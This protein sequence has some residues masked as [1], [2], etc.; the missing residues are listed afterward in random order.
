MK[1][2]ITIVGLA[3]AGLSVPALAQGGPPADPYGDATVTRTDELTAVGARFDAQ[4][5]NHDGSLSADELAAGAPAGG[6]GGRG[7]R[8][9]GSR[10]DEDGDGKVSKDEY[11]TAQLRRF[12]SQDADKDGKLTKAERDAA[13]ERRGRGGPGGG[14]G[15]G[16]GGPPPGGAGGG[17]GSPDGQ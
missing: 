5:S 1:K 9:P 7:G 12:D 6:P 17:W 16:W 14:G 4:D 2:L 13:R 10:A 8:G 3:T 11:V 15:G